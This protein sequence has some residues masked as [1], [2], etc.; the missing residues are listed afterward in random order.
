MKR[1]LTELDWRFDY[2]VA[3]F[4]YNG[5]KV[6]RYVDYMIDKWGERFTSKLE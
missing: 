1:L 5:N 3:P 2:Y 4:L 6:H